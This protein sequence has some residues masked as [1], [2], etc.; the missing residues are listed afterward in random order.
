MIA[1]YVKTIMSLWKDILRFCRVISIA[2]KKYV[3]DQLA[4]RAVVLTYY[5]LFAVVPA[6]ALVFGVANGF[7]VKEKLREVMYRQFADHRET[8]NWIWHY[9]DLTL[10][11]T[12]GDL[13]A[14]AG[15]VFLIWTVFWLAF[16]VENSFNAIWQLPPRK[17][18]FRKLSD[19][20]S[21]ILITP[22][23]LV[24]LSSSGVFLR[25]QIP[26]FFAKYPLINGVAVFFITFGFELLPV[27]FACL[28]FTL[29]YFMVPNTK[30]KLSSALFGGVITGIMFHIL[31]NSFIFVQL[32]LSR[33]NAIYGSFAVLPLFL[34][35]L[36]WSWQI[37]LLGAQFAFV[38]QNIDS[39]L[40]VSEESKSKKLIR[41]YQLLIGGLI[42]G[43]YSQGKG[44][45]R[46]QE[47]SR[48]FMLSP[49]ETHCYLNS[50]ETAGVVARVADEADVA[51][52]PVKPADT[53][54]VC[55]ALS[56]LD[57]AGKNT[58]DELLHAQFVPVSECMDQLNL[59]AAG[60]R[61]NRLLKDL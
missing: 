37:T 7:Q 23:L 18:I 56:A 60:S 6:C 36:Q 25:A 24:L 11:K 38:H 2:L 21:V 32:S 22:V 59:A 43:S 9:A 17:N 50:L 45:V 57:Q 33:S 35:W 54:T 44:M 41:K 8:I 42:Y 49:V 34:L 61:F 26:A 20:L 1:G 4:Q 40:F 46:E 13:I 58:P 12:R 15:I 5:T 16:N 3:K 31:Q 27:V 28:L 51:F 48:K 29:I 14:G 52:L 39:G 19:Y 10:E 55:D 47:I 30:V 53:F